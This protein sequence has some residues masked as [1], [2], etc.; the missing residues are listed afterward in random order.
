MTAAELQA[1]LPKGCTVALLQGRWVIVWTG[2]GS[3]PREVLARFGT[4]E[5]RRENAKGGR[6]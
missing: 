5:E 6:R 1:S 2:Q 3:M 4:R